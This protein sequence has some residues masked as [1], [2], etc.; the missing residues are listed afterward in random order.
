MESSKDGSAKVVDPFRIQ[1]K[2]Y[3]TPP[4]QGKKR[5]SASGSIRKDDFRDVIDLHD[6]KHDSDANTQRVFEVE[7]KIKSSQLGADAKM[8]GFRD[9]EGLFVIR[10][11]LSPAAQLLWARICLTDYSKVQHTNLTNLYGA[12]EDLW[13]KACAQDSLQGL[14]KLRWSSLGYHYD[15]TARTYSE[16][17]HSAFPKELALFCDEMAQVAG[18]TVRSEAAIINY[19]PSSSCMGAH[20]DDA[21][22]T[23]SHP[24]ISLSLGITAIFLIGGPTKATKP[25]ALFLKSG[26]VVIMGGKS[27]LA[28][29][30]VPRL[31]ENTLSATLDKALQELVQ[32]T[33]AG[34]ASTEAKA[35]DDLFALR[36]PHW[37]LVHKYLKSNRINAN[38]RQVVDETYTFRTG[39]KPW[40]ERSQDS[41]S[42]GMMTMS[43]K[44]DDDD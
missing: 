13:H 12:Q 19:Y 27:R 39:K 32:E 33:A 43:Q 35:G 44:A 20:L 29:H 40:A 21:E 26:D 25:T 16:H 23:Q 3:K 6:F 5:K 30:G 11:A 1:E 4:Q 41:E 10:A 31:I 42:M 36:Y 37:T 9:I 2:R 18:Y 17:N 22:F 24:I 38:V 14:D 7:P 28:Y 15:W 34:S 8:F